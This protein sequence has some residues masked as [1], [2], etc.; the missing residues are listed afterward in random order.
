MSLQPKISIIIPIY[1]AEKYIH[2]CIESILAQ[3]FKDF[4]VLLIDDGSP[5][6]SG[7][8]CDKYA[9]LDC[10]VRVFHNENGGVS[11]ARQFGID[12]ARGEYTIH[13]DPDDWV[14]PD[15]LEDLYAKAQE[16]DAD[17]VMCDY[18]V[19]FKNE[20]QYRKSQPS[21]LDHKTVLKEM[22][23]Q[24][25]CSCWNKLIRRSCY[26]KYGIKFDPE[27]SYCEDLMFNSSLL[28]H[29]IRISYIPKAYYH[30][31]QDANPD[32]I[33]HSV[34]KYYDEVEYE[35]DMMLLKK[36]Q[37]KFYGTIAETVSQSRIS[38]YALNNAF[39]GNYY[40]SKNF[41]EKLHHLLPLLKPQ[42][43]RRPHYYLYL[44]SCWG[45]YALAYRLFF[46][47]KAIKKLNF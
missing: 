7:E 12:N 18:F 37:N 4:E 26:I 17:M 44:L 15:M 30:Y 8:I 41:K 31:V 36:F 33:I 2:H 45:Y 38:Y 20:Q 21:A 23:L 19:N 46:I 28:L 1:K 42:G 11:F 6:K 10:R 35:Y 5:D 22:F 24:L 13:A 39:F 14:E 40:D 34:Y 16:E 27:L 25:T 47:L 29:D 9:E 32:S 43:C 3:T